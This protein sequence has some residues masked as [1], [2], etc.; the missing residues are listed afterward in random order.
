MA[1]EGLRER[2]KPPIRIDVVDYE[3][4]PRIQALPGEIELETHVALAV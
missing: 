4:A 3:G 1:G 2:L